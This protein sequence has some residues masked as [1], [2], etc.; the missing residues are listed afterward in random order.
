MPTDDPSGIQVHPHRQ[1]GP[2]SAGKRNVSYVADPHFIGLLW[3][4]PVQQQVG[5]YGIRVPALGGFGDKAARLNGLQTMHL[6]H[7]C[8]LIAADPAS[9]GAQVLYDPT[10]TITPLVLLK[11]MDDLLLHYLYFLLWLMCFSCLPGVIATSAYAQGP[12]LQLTGI[13]LFI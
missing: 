4:C 8:H 3:D 6:K 12:A 1:V 11:C 5:A 2:F 13:F 10:R 7:F 9:C